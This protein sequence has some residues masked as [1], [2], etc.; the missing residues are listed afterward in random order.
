MRERVEL[1]AGEF[2]ASPLPDGG[3]RVGALLP[4]DNPA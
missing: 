3:F 2:Q 4:L 1:F